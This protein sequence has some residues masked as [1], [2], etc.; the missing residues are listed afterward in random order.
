VHERLLLLR[1]TSPILLQTGL[2][3]ALA[4]LA[5]TE[6]LGHQRPFFAAIAAVVTLGLTAGRRGRRALEL[7]AG[8]T[9][10]IAV[11]DLLVNLV[12]GGTWQL[13]VIVPSA[14]AVAVLLGGTP[15]VVSQTGISAVLVVTLEQPDGFSFV[16][17]FDAAI[18]CASA[19]LV[20][21]LVLPLN[22]LRLVRREA[23]PVLEALAGTL[24]DIAGA[25]DAR[26]RATAVRA[27]QRARATDV[28]AQAFTDALSAGREIAVA[29][30]PRRGALETVEG[31]VDAGAQVDL[32][33]RNTRVLARGALRAIDVGDSVPPEATEAI[34]DLARAV[35]GLEA[36]LMDP[37]DID[38]ARRCAISAAQ[39]ANAVLEQTANLSISMIVASVRA[40]AVDLLRGTGLE[41]EEAVRL[42][43][44]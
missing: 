8:V 4:W 9:L 27:L 16:R 18:G 43:R 39:R 31:Y 6:L 2:A 42:V 19:L 38:A 13:A 20:G 3:I 21:F 36:W 22:P 17:T 5:A 34:R 41:R 35:R 28:L 14:M 1:V 33:V 37:R 23:V 11:G 32:A 10:G 25:L 7:A 44:G 26:D 15:A 40:A 30:L 12:G 24:D 29:A